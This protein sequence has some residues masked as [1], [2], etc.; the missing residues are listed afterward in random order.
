MVD[1]VP[2]AILAGRDVK[3]PRL[4]GAPKLDPVKKR[5]RT[6]ARP[7]PARPDQLHRYVDGDGD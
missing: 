5:D 6:G 7:S 1:D 4:P 3:P 2:Q